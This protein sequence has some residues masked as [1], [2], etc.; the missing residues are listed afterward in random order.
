LAGRH[1]YIFGGLIADYERQI[2][3]TEE[4]EPL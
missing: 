3:N 1:E 4:P 2:L